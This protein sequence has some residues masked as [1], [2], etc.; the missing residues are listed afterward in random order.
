M[1]PRGRRGDEILLSV[2]VLERNGRFERVER[3]RARLRGHEYGRFVVHRVR[4]R[5]IVVVDHRE[6]QRVDY[7]GSFDEFNRRNR[8]RV[9]NDA[10]VRG[11]N[12]E[13][14]WRNRGSW[15]FGENGGGRFDGMREDEERR[16]DFER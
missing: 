8:R 12:Y 5:H 15:G 2:R 1:R 6:E 11:G 9:E 7:W 10:R 14:G 16:R 4:G 13:Y 3:H